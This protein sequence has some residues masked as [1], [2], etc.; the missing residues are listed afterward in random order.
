TFPDRFFDVGICEAHAVGFA[1]GLAKSG[2][3]PIVAIYSTFLQ[4][5][6]DHIFQEVALQNLPVVFCLDRGGLAGPDGPTHHGVFDTVYLR[7]FPSFAVMA[8]GDETDVEPMLQFALQHPGPIS[9]RYPKANLEKISRPSAPIELGQAEV[10]EWGHDGA[11][12]AYGAL[13]PN[14]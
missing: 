14:C 8:P 3:K 4:R 1:A 10:Y 5:S 9:L 7:F 12:I 2:T 6:F 13:F 11:L